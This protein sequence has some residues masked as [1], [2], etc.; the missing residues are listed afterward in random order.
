MRYIKFDSIHPLGIDTTQKIP[1]TFRDTEGMHRSRLLK[2]VFYAVV[3]MFFFTEMLRRHR[4]E[5]LQKRIPMIKP[6]TPNY[7]K[8]DV[9]FPL[10]LDMISIN[11]QR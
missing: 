9:M 11:Y 7:H 10:N 6:S 3:R 1:N 4:R 5:E 8:R 2:K